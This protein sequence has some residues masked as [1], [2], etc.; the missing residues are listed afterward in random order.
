[1]ALSFIHCADLHLGTPFKGVAGRFSATD[2]VHEIL[3]APEA[4]F[5]KIVDFAIEKKVDF[6]LFAGD[7]TDSV[8]VNWRSISVLTAGLEKLAN[9]NIKVFAVAGNHDAMPNPTLE[10]AFKNCVLFDCKNIE[11]HEISGKAV[12]G[13]I[14]FCAENAAK[15][16]AANFQR[17]NSELFQIALFHGNIG[18]RQGYDN[19]SPASIG[20]LVNCNMDY[21]ALGHIHETAFLSEKNPVIL[22][23]GATLSRD[24]NESSPKGFYHVQVDDFKNVKCDF[25]AS[26]PLLFCRLDIRLENADSMPEI[27]NQIRKNILAFVTSNNADKYFMELVL[28]GSTTLDRELREQ[29]DEDLHFLFSDGLPG[30]CIIGRITIQT[31]GNFDRELFCRENIFA[32]DLHH[33]FKDEKSADFPT[34]QA[35][36][37]TLKRNYGSFIDSENL[38]FEELAED[39]ENEIIRLITED[40]A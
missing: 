35:E 16:T 2:N 20:D 12:I 13:G 28:N 7:I 22:Y 23:S 32:A 26:S 17:Q 4:A 29:T 37:G 24:V 3:H 39:A 38:S 27:K 10:N 21:W 31:V 6:V 40:F 25:I 34:I 8:N 9:A 15:N 14:S 5:E 30:C 11:Y 19:Y 1:M 33:S 36:L 18:G